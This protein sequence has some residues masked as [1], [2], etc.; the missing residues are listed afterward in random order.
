MFSYT[1]GLFWYTKLNLFER[2][3]Y[4][5]YKKIVIILYLIDA[6]KIAPFGVLEII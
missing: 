2:K 4:K 5:M 1:G 3:T 6:L